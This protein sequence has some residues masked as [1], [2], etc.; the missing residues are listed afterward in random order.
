M[1]AIVFFCFRY[2]EGYDC[3]YNKVRRNENVENRLE[4]A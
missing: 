2:A 4:E 1:P 3:T